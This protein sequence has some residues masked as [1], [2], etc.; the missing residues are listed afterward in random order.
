MS[1]A[2]PHYQKITREYIFPIIDKELKLVREAHPNKKI[3]N[4]GVGDIVQPL[5][6]TIVKALTKACNEMG[7]KV[8][9]YGPSCGYHF[10]KK[11][12]VDN[13]YG[14]YGIKASEV[15]ISEGTIHDCVN[16]LDILDQ[17]NEIAIP[18][19]AYPSYLDAAIMDGRTRAAKKGNDF[20]DIVYLPCT[21]ETGF[22][23]RPPKKACD[24]IY[25]CSPHNPT[26]MA[27]TRSDYEEWIDYAKEHDALII[28]DAAYE[29]FI[30]S[31]NV[32]RS[33]YEIKG[34]KDVA[35][36]LRTFSKS[37][38][39]TG[40]RCAYSIVP[41]AIKAKLGKED[42]SL[43]KLWTQ[44]Q[45]AKS[46]GVS[47]P[48]QRAAEAALTKKAHEET[49]E[50]IED[51][52]IQ[53]KRLKDGLKD[54]GQTCY[55]GEDCP[56]IWWKCPEGVSSWEFFRHLLNELHLLCIPGAGFG[57]RGEGY[58]RLS[59]FTNEESAKEAVKRFKKI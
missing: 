24:V 29:C 20:P 14:R 12:I 22:L 46:N 31:D 42:V 16:L 25:L 11:A 47:Y 45:H 53:T 4:F 13:E 33:I 44:R 41:E 9:G 5:K 2:N 3:L 37:A 51:Y 57:K 50:D 19:P 7:E 15:F 39:F 21:E 18:D 40:L 27:L 17:D 58:V 48:V 10:L 6:P 28:L 59:G 34:A 43:H 26:G 23:P 1:K 55:G 54:H 38:G 35:I 36:E 56:Y 32:P 49:I 8:V 30:R 52:L